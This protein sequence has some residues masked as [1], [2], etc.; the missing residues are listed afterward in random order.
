[1]SSRLHPLQRD[2]GGLQDLRLLWT[3]VAGR[4]PLGSRQ[5]GLSSPSSWGASAEQRSPC[6]PSHPHI[7][8]TPLALGSWGACSVAALALA[9]LG[10]SGR[11]L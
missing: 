1:M 3:M 5:P 10:P 11:L 8:W 2:S 7:P 4:C 6:H 9:P